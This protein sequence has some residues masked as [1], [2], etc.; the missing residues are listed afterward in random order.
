MISL[1]IEPFMFLSV[2]ILVLNGPSAKKPQKHIVGH[3]SLCF[4][5]KS[6]E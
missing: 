5:P 1:Q 6:I 4:A 2:R 3:D